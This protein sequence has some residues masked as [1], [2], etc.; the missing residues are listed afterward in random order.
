MC[1]LFKEKDLMYGFIEMLV[2]LTHTSMAIIV[3]ADVMC[4]LQVAKR[5]PT[6]PMHRLRTQ[7]NY[8]LHLTN[9]T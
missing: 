2:K 1:P 3:I 8:I 9:M 6:L 5:H 4:Y 7:C